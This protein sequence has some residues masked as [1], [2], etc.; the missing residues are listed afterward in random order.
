MCLKNI[1]QKTKSLFEK[2][3]NKRTMYVFSEILKDHRALR[4]QEEGKKMGVEVKVLNMYKIFIKD[5]KMWDIDGG[6][7]EIKKGDVAW[8]LSNSVVSHY[9]AD[10]LSNKLVWPDIQSVRFADKFTTNTFFSDLGM[11][12]PSTVLLNSYEVEGIVEKVGGFPCII[13]RN[14]GTVGKFVEIVNNKEEVREFVENNF[15]SI[16]KNLVPVGKAGFL[17]QEFIEESKGV[18][19]RVLC[20]DGEVLGV[21]K[22]EAQEGFKSNVSLGGKAT[23]VPTDEKLR[24]YALKIMKEGNLFYAGIDFM[25]QGDDY[26]ALEVNTSAQFKG[27]EAATG[28]NVAEKII[29]KLIEKRVN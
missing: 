2:K 25:K 10:T 13:K 15:D 19:Y 16:K 5:G 6:E 24:E 9:I 8:I 21:I 27:F 29:E 22:R 17:L 18:D 4:F 3:E 11:P 14:I 20:L 28:M 12:T 23:V 7:I 26:T 1:I